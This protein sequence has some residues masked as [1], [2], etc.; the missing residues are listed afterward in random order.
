MH[1]EYQRETFRLEVDHWWYRAR[2]KIILAQFRNRYPTRRDL[3]ILDVGCG[4]GTL[5]RSLRRFGQ[6]TGL[7][8]SGAAAAA[9][10]RRSGC[11]VRVGT[12]PTGDQRPGSYDVVCLFDVLEHLED[13]VAALRAAR[14]LL[15]EH[16]TLFVTVPA[17]PWLFGI[18]DEI[19]EHRRRYTRTSLSTALTAA[20]FRTAQISYFNMLLCPLLLP[21]IC[22]RN[23]RRSG[24]HFEVRTRL[25]PLLERVFG[26]ERHLMRYLRLP[27]GLSLFG[28][29]EGDRLKGSTPT[30]LVHREA[31]ADRV[32]LS[33]PLVKAGEERDRETHAAPAES[34]P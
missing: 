9:A 23:L 34:I 14:R 30:T 17:L 27:F 16:G 18:H 6:V 26:F 15:G 29:A 3:R 2:Q 8:A 31:S 12:L 13:D 21:A 5:L 1:A 19:N 24:H 32:P 10:R 20:G 33:A 25:A 7:E 4:A 22:W 28:M 11:D